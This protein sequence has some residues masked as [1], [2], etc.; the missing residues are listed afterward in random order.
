M[1]CVCLNEVLSA[2]LAREKK[3]RAEY[4]FGIQ[5]PC[6]C[7]RALHMHCS[8]HSTFMTVARYKA[9]CAFHKDHSLNC[10]EI[11]FILTVV[12]QRRAHM[13]SGAF[14]LRLQSCFYM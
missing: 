14:F 9:F 2:L 11:L 4:S 6:S 13:H 7:S 8:C 12:I 5:C 3:N 1:D 10:H